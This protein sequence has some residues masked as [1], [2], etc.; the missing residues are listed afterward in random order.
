[1]RILLVDDEEDILEGMLAGIDFAALGFDGVYTASSAQEAREIL[2]KE[3]VDILLTDIEMPGE[4]GL[5]LLDWLRQQN[6]DIVTMFCTSYAN[7]DYAKK[8]VEMHSF[9]Y[10]LKPISYD[11]L[12]SHLEAA[13]QEVRKKHSES[14]YRQMGEYWLKGRQENQTGFWTGV[15][16]SVS[17]LAEVIRTGLDKGISYREEDRFTLCYVR[18]MD[19]E[20]QPLEQWKIYGFRNVAEELFHQNGLRLEATILSKECHWSLVLD[21]GRSRPRESFATWSWHC[22]H[23]RKSC[24]MCLPMGTTVRTWL[25]RKRGRPMKPFCGQTRRMFCA[26][27]R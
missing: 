11:E 14:A 13:I 19:K 23:R 22:W 4:S 12:R 26:P 18:V 1:M 10:Y 5:E 9:D 3:P 27:I 20:P 2:E 7:F 15:L 25:C 8:A 21:K 17:P 6:S 24:S 16:A